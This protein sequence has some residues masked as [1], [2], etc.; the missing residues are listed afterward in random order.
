[1]ENIKT[2]IQT[3]IRADNAYG[4]EG[5]MLA[6]YFVALL[7]ILFY[8]RDK[9]KLETIVFPQVIILIFLYVG[10]SVVSVFF[11][12]MEFFDGRLFW[13]LFTP[14]VT[15]AGFTIFVTGIQ[16]KWKQMLCVLVLI[17]VFFYSGR[18]ALSNDTYKK[19]ENI[20]RL[21]EST[22]EITEY[23]L[24]NEEEPLILVPYTISHPFRQIST[25][26]RVLFGEDA[27]SGRIFGA[28]GDMYY[29]SSEMEKV[30]PDL[31][32]ISEKIKEY[33][34]DYILFDTV[35]TEL[36]EDGNINIYGYP[37]DK[38]YVGDR[39]PTISY[40]DL[41]QISVVDDSDPH[42]DLSE[43]DLEYCGR[44]SQYVLYKSK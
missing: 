13:L 20:Y 39:T 4:G 30:I 2:L 12:P 27:T 7:L 24:N 6:L 40:D 44:F 38:R 1:M 18:F 10:V 22:V 37:E 19:A 34:V 17:P 42:W 5:M 31:N 36:C 16:D 23:V 15:S 25:K 26:V 14:I 8:G 43:Y 33:D 35:Y 11:K 21:P 9:K 29:M 3:I 28:P 41:K 32:F